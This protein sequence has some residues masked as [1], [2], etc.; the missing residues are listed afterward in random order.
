MESIKLELLESVLGTDVGAIKKIVESEGVTDKEVKESLKALVDNRDQ[1]LIKRVKSDAHDEGH[2]RGLR[3]SREKLEKELA[4]EYGVEKSDVKSMIKA[5]VEKER[6]AVKLNPDDV[7]KSDVYNNLKTDLEKKIEEKEN[8]I[9]S[10]SESF[11]QENVNNALNRKV[12]TLIQKGGY[13]L[14]EDAAKREMHLDWLRTKLRD[15]VDFKIDG[16]SISVIK[17]GKPLKDDKYQEVGFEDYFNNIAG[18]ILD[19]GSGGRGGTGNETQP[20][21]GDSGN[22]YPEFKNIEQ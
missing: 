5:L 10:L 22:D 8:E 21:S 17:D 15:G 12:N 19:K 20:D 13:K 7:L 9:S 16:D 6:E 3:E 14:P 18:V 1:D 11:R 4:D 2:G